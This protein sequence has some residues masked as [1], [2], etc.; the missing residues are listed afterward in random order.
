M[1]IRWRFLLVILSLPAP[2]PA[3]AGGDSMTNAG[4]VRAAGAVDSVF[5]LRT[6]QS[7]T[8]AGGD[9]AAYLMARL[10]VR[11]IPRDLRLRVIVDPTV[12]R[13]SGRIADLP[14]EALVELGPLLALLDTGTTVDAWASLQRAGPTAVRFRLD[15][16]ALGGIGIPEL[17]LAPVLANVGARYPKLTATGRDLFVETP[18]DGQL[19]LV[20][21]GVSLRTPPRPAPPPPPSPHR[22]DRSH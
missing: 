16:A 2:L 17:A 9:W 10:G 19:E 13:I 22:K 20:T 7:D 11:P 12:I 14:R 6:R 8:V 5:L 18:P 21:G 1:A 3:Q 4:V 15:S